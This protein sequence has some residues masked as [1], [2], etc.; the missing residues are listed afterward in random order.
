MKLLVTATFLIATP[1]LAQTQPATSRPFR[2]LANVS[3]NTTSRTFDERS[4]FA[5]FLEEGSTSRA[6]EGGT[7]LGFEL[8]AIY[9]FT[10]AFGVLGRFEVLTAE[11]DA[12]YDVNAPHPLYFNQPRSASDETAAL[13]YNEQSLDVDAVYTLSSGAFVVDVFGGATLFF[14]ETEL[15]DEITT[16]SVYPFDELSI[17]SASTVKLKENPVGF[18]VGGAL[19]YRFTDVLGVSFQAKFSRATLNLQ[20]EAGEPIEI[21][22]GGFRVGAGIRI[23]F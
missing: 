17:T 11:H 5:A 14:T 6:Y 15:I 21:D 1:A 12:S 9:N 7:G 19:T 16:N 8:G 2:V 4:T 22:A 18:N 23:A 20:R 13:E 10:P 3:Y